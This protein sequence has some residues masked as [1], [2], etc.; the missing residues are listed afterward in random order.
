MRGRGGMFA[1]TGGWLVRVWGCCP[2]VGTGKAGPAQAQ[3]HEQYSNAHFQNNSTSEVFAGESSGNADP[4][5]GRG[6]EVRPTVGCEPHKIRRTGL[7][8]CTTGQR[9]R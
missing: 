5:V 2:V 4:E 1:G 3:R 7:Q 6:R 9:G 8:A